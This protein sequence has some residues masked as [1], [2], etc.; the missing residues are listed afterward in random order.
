MKVFLFIAAA[1]VLFASGCVFQK[2]DEQDLLGKYRADLPDGAV[3]FLEL[4]SKGACVQE[5]RLKSGAS[6]S[7]R[8]RWRYDPKLKC[9]YLEGTRIALTPTRKINADIGQIL[10]GN[11]GALSVSR[12]A[13]G[14]VTITLHEGIDYRKQ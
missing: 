10:P 9:L 6:Y 7:A 14:S 3:E 8:G 2:T 1:S 12:S 4:L 11:T 5:I 13:L